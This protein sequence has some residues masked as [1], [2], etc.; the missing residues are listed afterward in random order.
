MKLLRTLLTIP[1][2]ALM[3]TGNTAC[4]GE[5]TS[6]QPGEVGKV[7]GTNGL[8]AEVHPPG[9]FRLDY[10]LI[11]A[12]Q[13][14][15]RAQVNKST[16]QLRIEHLFLPKSNINI[17]NVEV[18][19]QFQVKPDAASINK[20]FT[21]IRPSHGEGQSGE[22]SRV[23]VISDDM[24]YATYI[25]RLAP[26][27]IVTALRDHTVEEILSAVP[28]ISHSTRDMINQMLK[29]SPIEVTEVGFPN[30]IGNIPH[31][32]MEKMH[33]L[34]AVNADRDRR[35]KSLEADIVVET[36]RQAFQHKRLG[37]N[38]QNAA[39]AGISYE[40]YVQ[41]QALDTLADA[42]LAGTPIG[43]GSPAPFNI[44]AGRSV[45][46]KDAAS[47]QP[48]APAPTPADSKL[49]KMLTPAPVPAAAAAQK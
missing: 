41:L 8:E 9:T 5:Q 48:P 47:A 2:L 17:S 4:L 13:K 39:T 12:C 26:N 46:A 43:L 37:N 35:I 44:P 19:I 16:Q 25:Q 45:T 49:Q 7:L 1:A 31:E 22:T 24:L 36:Q 23:L 14:L 42:A 34:Y 27:A 29:D 11:S 15:V 6:I 32:V 33:Q 38:M 10:C 20:V 40:T 28:E 18:G 30:G 3:L 21:E